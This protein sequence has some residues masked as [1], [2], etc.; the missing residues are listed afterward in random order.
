M[1]APISALSEI[2]N[3]GDLFIRQLRNFKISKYRTAYNLTVAMFVRIY[4]ILTTPWGRPLISVSGEIVN[5]R[6]S[7]TPESSKSRNP[8]T[9]SALQLH[10]VAFLRRRGDI[11]HTLNV[12]PYPVFMRNGQF[13]VAFQSEKFK[14]STSRGILRFPTSAGGVGV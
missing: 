1:R 6:E 4:G 7:D 8:E 5:F 12:R 14:I 9:Y 13:T 3:Y 2:S 10:R 11:T